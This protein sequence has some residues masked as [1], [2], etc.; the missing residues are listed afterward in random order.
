MEREIEKR[1]TLGVVGKKRE[2]RTKLR[3]GEGV[4]AKKGR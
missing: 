4:K 3:I 2:K 1:V